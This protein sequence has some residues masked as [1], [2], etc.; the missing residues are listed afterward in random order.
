MNVS[1]GRIVEKVENPYKIK[2]KKQRIIDIMIDENFETR[3]ET[4][5]GKDR[6]YYPNTLSELIKQNMKADVFVTYKQNGDIEMHLG[7]NPKD[8]RE[9]KKF[10][11]WIQGWL[12]TKEKTPVILDAKSTFKEIRKVI[13]NYAEK[14]TKMA[15]NYDIT[16]KFRCLS[17]DSEEI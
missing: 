15:D 12:N 14:C 11:G 4:K 8:K 16:E 9:I 1:F 10:Y 7:E 3:D 13:S 2:T 17:T 5:F 6:W